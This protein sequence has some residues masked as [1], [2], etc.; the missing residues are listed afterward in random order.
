MF[1]LLFSV[2]SSS[3]KCCYSRCFNKLLH[4][5]NHFWS[6]NSTRSINIK[7]LENL[8]KS[9]VVEDIAFAQRSDCLFHKLL[10]L[11][12]IKSSRSVNIID[13]PNLI[14]RVFNGINLALICSQTEL[15]NILFLLFF[16]LF[17]EFDIFTLFNLFKLS[18]NVLYIWFWYDG[19]NITSSLVHRSK[20]VGDIEIVSLLKL[21]FKSWF[22][23]LLS[24]VLGPSLLLSYH[25]IRLSF[26]FNIVEVVHVNIEHFCKKGLSINNIGNRHGRHL[27][28]IFIVHIFWHWR[29]GLFDLLLLPDG[30]WSLQLRWIQRREF[31]Q[32]SLRLSVINLWLNWFIS[33]FVQIWFERKA[34][35]LF[36]LSLLP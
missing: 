6:L 10:G 14:N 1:L 24:L 12:F 20:I 32:I 21:L 22:D 11:L 35:H 18:Y 13:I 36:V 34:L 19:G 4:K 26:E 27:F 2:K 5:W 8:I 31:F 25:L 29:H 7:Q 16:L 3:L 30:A 9:L 23:V 17:L 15:K 33:F 28:V